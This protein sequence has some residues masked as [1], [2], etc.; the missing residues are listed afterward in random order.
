MKKGITGYLQYYGKLPLRILADAVRAFFE[1]NCFHLS[2]A[3]AFY[4]I[5]SVIPILYLIFYVSGF[6]LGSSETA[7]VA[8]VDFIKDLNPYVEEKLIFEVKKLS[9]VSGFVGWIAFAFLLW[10]STMFVTSLETAFTAIFRVENKRHPFRSLFMG[11]A[12]IPAG[13]VMILFSIV[14]TTGENIIGK[15]EVGYFLL[16]STLLRYVIPL[17]IIVLFFTLIYKI[18]PNKK[19]PFTYAL[20]GGTVS[21]I[22]LEVAKQL[23]NLYLSLGGNPAGFVYGSLNALVY[24]VIWV[25]YL[26]TITLFTA[27]IVSV[28]ERREGDM[29]SI[30][31]VP[32]ILASASPRRQEL[33][34]VLG[35]EFDVI[36]SDVSEEFLNGET[37]RDH[38]LRLARDK[39]MTVSHNNPSVWVLGAD[40]VVVIDD[41]VLGKPETQNEERAMLAKLSGQS[42]KVLTGFSIAKDGKLFIDDVVE[43]TVTFK[44]IHEDEIEWYTS[45][46]EPY[47]KAGGYAVQG[48]AAFFVKEIHGSY[49][50][51]VGLPLTEV[52]TALKHVGAL[53]FERET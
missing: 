51:V 45:T 4:S 20:I 6:V 33:L 16:N 9:D 38:V 23:F 11:V 26:A 14:V 49:A 7:Y 5:I 50:N 29:S 32:L 28:L 27:E 2:A 8:V 31:T 52:V 53:T 39:S 30:K 37:P 44:E 3:V 40:T 48:M 43:S 15:W 34:R 1:D 12:V 13:L 21:T 18:I 25:F 19:V 42:H 41:E 35:I 36:P 22:L 17:S 47:D 24:V 46:K 10:I